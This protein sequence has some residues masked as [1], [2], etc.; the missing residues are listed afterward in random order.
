MKIKLIVIKQAVKKR[1]IR[2]NKHAL[3]T[4][5]FVALVALRRLYSKTNKSV[6]KKQYGQHALRPR[7]DR[8]IELEY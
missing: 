6:F 7:R 1:T 8:R 3:I 4:R 5:L 2:N